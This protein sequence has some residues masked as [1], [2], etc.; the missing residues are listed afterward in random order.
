[1]PTESDIDDALYELRHFI[2]LGL[3]KQALELLGRLVRQAGNDPRLAHYRARIRALAGD[4]PGAMSELAAL[5]RENPR[6]L[7]SRIALGRL[8][9]ASGDRVGALRCYHAAITVDPGCRKARRLA[10]FLL[11]PPP[12][13]GEASQT[14][15]DVAGFLERVNAQINGWREP[16]REIPAELR[17]AY[18]MGGRVP[19]GEVY[20]NHSLLEVMGSGPDI[21]LQAK[22][23]NMFY[24]RAAVAE[25]IRLA[26][27]GEPAR[28]GET[29]LWL[30]DALDRHPCRGKTV[31]VFG[32]GCP[33]FEGVVLA[34]GG[35][36][37]V[38]EYQVRFSDYPGLV[39][40][41]PDEFEAS[42]LRP[43]FGVS[44]SSF[45][46]DG[47]GRYGD[48]LDPV[49]DL[50]AMRKARGKIAEGGLLFLSVPV[51]M[52]QI[53]WNANRIYGPL[54]LPELLEGWELVEVLGAPPGLFRSLHP[55][56]IDENRWI[57]FFRPRAS[58]FL[59]EW[60][61]VLR[62]PT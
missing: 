47:L 21:R 9:A 43:D 44:I 17:D 7:D 5:S 4:V 27:A 1:M 25:W 34:F 8:S 37:L 30:Q 53:L 36:P 15:L 31:A 23:G 52:D 3:H 35:K 62:N 55:L 32:S 10:E 61:F 16:P 50:E 48:P 58:G 13:P 2:E 14:P 56:E 29:T 20:L 6:D 46:H 45:E 33:T 22:L 59:P 12:D 60:L 49:G 51:Q 41:T 40:M 26:R 54:R 38:V 28:Y 19:V 18:T 24:D 57:E 42:P 11:M 39:F